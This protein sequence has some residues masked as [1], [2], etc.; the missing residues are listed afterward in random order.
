MRPLK[1]LSLSIA[2]ILPAGVALADLTA[3]PK[4]FYEHGLI[5]DAKRGFI[6]VTFDSSATNAEKA[7]ALSALGDIAFDQNKIGLAISTWRDLVERF[8]ESEEAKAVEERLDQLGEIV[9]ATTTS[10]L[11]NQIARS[12]LRNGDWWSRGRE[13]GITIDTS[14]IPKDEAALQWYDR[15]IAEFP[16]TPSATIA[17]KRKFQTV[18]GWEEPGKY[19]NTYG[20]KSTGDVQKLID[21]FAELETAAPDDVDLQRFRYMIAQSFWNNRK[22]DETREWL[23][24][25][26]DADEEKGGFYA[27]LAEWRLEKVDY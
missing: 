4:T 14:W 8:P 25:V 13:E 26:I 10:T 22:F 18:Y 23:Q 12:H 24:R 15:V 2:L 20:V 17:L 16:G 3:L 11:D 9:E 7:S 19:G 21:V 5:E 1:T 27:D 6:E